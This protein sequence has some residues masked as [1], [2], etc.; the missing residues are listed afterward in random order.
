[1]KKPKLIDI[2]QSYLLA[3]DALHLAGTHLVLIENFIG[4]FKY[5]KPVNIAHKEMQEIYNKL[6]DNFEAWQGKSAIDF[7]MKFKYRLKE[8]QSNKEAK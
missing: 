6:R 7:D 8:I 4:E 1:M 3:L 2:I 5:S